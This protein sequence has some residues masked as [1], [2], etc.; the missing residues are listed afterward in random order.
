VRQLLHAGIH[1]REQRGKWAYYRL[2][3]DTLTDMAS[4]IVSGGD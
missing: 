3:P 1:R 4:L 2:V